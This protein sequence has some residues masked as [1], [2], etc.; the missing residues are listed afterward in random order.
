[1]SQ[2]EGDTLRGDLIANQ[3]ALADLNV[4]AD[5]LRSRLV[6]GSNDWA[7]FFCLLK[8]IFAWEKHA[9]IS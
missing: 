4:Y 5:S 9:S 7:F 1:M 6:D 8:R 2:K 3:K